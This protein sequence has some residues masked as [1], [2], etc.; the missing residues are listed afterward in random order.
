MFN[1][2]SHI[3]KML[4]YFF[5][6]VFIITLIN[7]CTAQKE[8]SVSES[9]ET[10]QQQI[11]PFFVF[12]KE[13]NQIQFP[14]IGGLNTPRPQFVDID[15]DGDSDLF[16]QE[17]SSEL[18][19]FENR[20][21]GTE[22]AL[23]WITNT[24]K[25][26]DIGEWFRFVDM[27][28]DGDMDLLTEQPYSYIRYYRNEGTAEMASYTLVADSLR[29]INGTPIFSDRQNIPNV[30]DIDCDGMPDLF[31]GSL[32]G[33]LAR[34]ESQGRDEKG[35]P[36]F[37]LITKR[38]Q[39]IEI[40]K[41]FGTLHGANTMA[42]ID[43]DNDGD[44]DIFWGDFFEPSILLLENT[45][46]CS[47]PQFV[48]EPRSFPP[49]SPV[50]TSGYNVPGLVDWEGDGDMDLFLGVLGGAYNTNETTA[51]NF[52]FF[53]QQD[54]R[55]EL[56]TE[57]FLSMIDTGDESIVTTGDLDGDGDLDMLVSN[58]IDPDNRNSSVV[59]QFE[60]RGTK[61][62][63]EF[64]LSGSLELPAAYHYAPELGDLDGDGKADLIL[65]NWKGGMDFYR[66]TGS[67]FEL[68]KENAADLPRGSNAVPSLGDLDA[69]GD[70]DLIAGQSGGGVEFFR[71]E[72][73]NEAPEFIS[74]PD[75]FPE[76]ESSQRSAPA[77]Y[78]IDSDGDL[79]LFLG[80]KIDGYLFFRNTGTS[81]DP[82]FTKEAFPFTVR[83]TQLGSPHF[84]DLDSDGVAEF[85]SGTRGG[86]VLFYKR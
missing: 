12:Y 51:D 40:V 60:N 45:G 47:N 24:Y 4:K 9:A 33:T 80:T 48:G 42:F 59:Y 2:G 76:V 27:D 66:N 1:K 37:K 14:F 6:A 64:H 55:F 44:Q 86:G 11:D 65:G 26:L 85:L 38:F 39:D 69:D 17:H 53:E 79:D 61:Q 35:T 32:D 15:N 49:S 28:Q 57:Q 83:T 54:D 41:Q 50:M 7:A 34:Y 62:N 56:Q 5:S 78:D 3:L 22:S 21:P 74:V 31:I 81:T 20:E 58:K 25:D 67:G 70:L 36:L 19:F 16:L 10:Y 29:D 23:K 77:L 43:I 63:P 82:A 52:Y 71:N 46:S 30:T 68:I 13:G 75:V 73:T 8:L 84:I 18:M 72:G